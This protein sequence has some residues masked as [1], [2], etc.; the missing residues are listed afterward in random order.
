[1][2]SAANEFFDDYRRYLGEA[3][4]LRAAKN[5][6]YSWSAFARDL[7]LGVSTLS[8]VLNGKYGL[9][10]VRAREVAKRL[11]LTESHCEHFCDLLAAQFS[12]S[13]EEKNRARLSAHLRREGNEQTLTL[14]KFKTISEWYHMAILELSETAGFVFDPDKMARRLGISTETVEESVNRLKRLGL[15]KV[16]GRKIKPTGSFTTVES[17]E[18][19]STAI[20]TF[21]KQ[22]I[23][24][25]KAAIEGQSMEERELSSTVFSVAREDLEAAKKELQQFR[26]SFALKFSKNANKKDVYCLSMQLF[27]LTEKERSL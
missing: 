3:F 13:K 20:R 22:I 10:S 25:A 6:R 18:L 24:K 14:D 17:K 1:M 8:E 19:A 21:H 7:G 27:S 4:K 23:D 5:P 9:S 15:V 12:R 2:S 26:R 16:R 11:H